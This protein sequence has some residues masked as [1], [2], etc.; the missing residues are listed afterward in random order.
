MGS[1][2]L[3]RELS[4]KSTYV[5][6]SAHYINKAVLYA[7]EIKMYILWVR[8]LRVL[9]D[10]LKQIYTPFYKGLLRRHSSQWK[11]KSLLIYIRDLLRNLFA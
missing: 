2:S 10:K 9:S 4:G 11:F 3:I 6:D 7:Q 5:I 8:G 1:A